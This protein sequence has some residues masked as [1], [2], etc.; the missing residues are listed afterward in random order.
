MAPSQPVNMPPGMLP[1]NPQVRS[2]PP[3]R[4]SK[5]LTI[6]IV[7]ALVLT[8]NKKFDLGLDSN[9]TMEIAA[10]VGAYLVGQGVADM[11][12]RGPFG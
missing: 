5:K 12:Q 2:K 11:R 6:T 9:T 3:F 10:V 8:A 4:V 1:P 7:T